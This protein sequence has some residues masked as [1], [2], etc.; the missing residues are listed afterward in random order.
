MI[1]VQTFVIVI[2]DVKDQLL[3]EE[4]TGAERDV[5]FRLIEPAEEDPHP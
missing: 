3:S 4:V 1:P 5:R 2:T